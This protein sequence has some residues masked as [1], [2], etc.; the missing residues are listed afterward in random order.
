MIDAA[1]R[2]FMTIR[3]MRSTVALACALHCW[4]PV[5]AVADDLATSDL[6]RQIDHARDAVFPALV[7]IQLVT[8]QFWGGEEIKGRSVG[9]GTIIT[10]E[11]HV[12]TNQHVTD[13]GR[14]FR[15]TLSDKQEISATLVGEDPLTD[16]AVLKLNLDELDDPTAPLPVATLGDSDTLQVGDHVLAMGSPYSLSRSV[17]R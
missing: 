9:S 12:L 16:L 14:R 6:R 15:C 1:F 11:G 7:N 5:R 8:S 3:V 13:N 4:A 2:D 17:T 10:A